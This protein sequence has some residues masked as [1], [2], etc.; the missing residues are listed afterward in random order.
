M[1][2]IKFQSIASNGMFYYLPFFVLQNVPLMY[3]Y[4]SIILASN[5]MPWKIVWGI[6]HVYT[7]KKHSCKD[8]GKMDFKLEMCPLTQMSQKLVGI[9]L[10]HFI[11]WEIR[12]KKCTDR[13]NAKSSLPVHAMLQVS[14]KSVG[15]CHIYK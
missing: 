13:S 12:T 4:M 1:L 10:L 14:R 9:N 3:C 11:K 2:S 15:N 6:Y 5:I 7:K 8:V